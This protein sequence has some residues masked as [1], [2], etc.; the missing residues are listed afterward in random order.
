M[1]RRRILL[2][3]NLI[4]ERRPRLG[5]ATVIRRL[6]LLPHLHRSPKSESPTGSLHFASLGKW[7]GPTASQAAGS[8]RPAAPPNAGIL[9]GKNPF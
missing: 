8:A 2:N 1:D 7:A 5:S 3:P 9:G 4:F 6:L